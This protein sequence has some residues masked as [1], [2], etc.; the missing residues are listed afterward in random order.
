MAS[1][2]VV[3]DE[4]WNRVAAALRDKHDA[5]LLIY[6]AIPDERIKE[7]RDTRPRYVAVV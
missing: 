4:E 7:L 5:K 2:A 1:R 6:E 3:D